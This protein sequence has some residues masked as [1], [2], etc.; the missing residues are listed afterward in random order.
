MSARPVDPSFHPGYGRPPIEPHRLIMQGGG[1]LSDED[2]QEHWKGSCSRCSWS[3]EAIGIQN[4]WQGVV[5]EFLRWHHIDPGFATQIDAPEPLPAA[6]SPRDRR[7]GQVVIVA[8]IVNIIWAAWN[9]L[10]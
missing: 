1:A 8:A 4:V 2:P 9:V 7:M 5:A 10:S 3:G 6:M